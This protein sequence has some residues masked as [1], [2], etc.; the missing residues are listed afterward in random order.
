MES[1]EDDGTVYYTTPD[2]APEPGVDITYGDVVVGMKVMLKRKIATLVTEVAVKETKRGAKITVIGKDGD[3]EEVKESK[4]AARTLRQL[5]DV[6]GNA[7][8]AVA[9]K[10]KKGGGAAKKSSAADDDVE[11]A[12]AD[13]GASLTY[14]IRAGEVKKGGYVLLKEKPCKVISVTTSKTG[15]HGHAKATITGLDLFT[16]KKYLEVCPTSHNM[17]APV[18]SRSEWSVTDLD[19]SSNAVTLMNEGGVIREDLNVPVGA[20][21]ELNDIAREILS[22]FDG[23]EAAGKSMS[24]VVLNA[25]GNEQ[26]VQIM[27][28]DLR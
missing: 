5:A 8:G 13:S 1:Y 7:V 14:P 20:D 15:K 2:E 4:P 17:T 3:G 21:G 9:K 6:D 16:G 19:R 27:E 22:K 26:I 11:I 28:K 24:V 12:S 18:V 23:M 10:S 25:M